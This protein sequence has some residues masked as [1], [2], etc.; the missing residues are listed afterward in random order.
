MISEVC[1]MKSTN[2]FRIFAVINSQHKN[3]RFTNKRRK[4]F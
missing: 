2:I 3:E 4:N 1:Y